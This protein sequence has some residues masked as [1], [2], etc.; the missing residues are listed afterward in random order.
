MTRLAF[1]SIELATTNLDG[2]AG[3]VLPE[4]VQPAPALTT[5]LTSDVA[6]TTAAAIAAGARLYVDPIDKPWGQTVAYVV[7]PSSLLIEIATSMDA[8]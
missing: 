5:L 6:A 1:A 8:R 4:E 2:A 3:F 7:G